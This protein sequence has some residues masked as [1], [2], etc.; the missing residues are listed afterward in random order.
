MAFL[1]STC[2]NRET[3]TSSLVSQSPQ[4]SFFIFPFREQF[5]WFFFFFKAFIVCPGAHSQW[6]ERS[7]FSGRALAFSSSVAFVFSCPRVKKKK[8]KKN[9]TGRAPVRERERERKRV[10]GV[11]VLCQSWALSLSHSVFV[12]LSSVGLLFLSVSA[13]NSNP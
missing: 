5:A 8:K 1:R 3:D 9:S 2:Q 11:L 6:I 10:R 7:P 4:R 13:L 12:S